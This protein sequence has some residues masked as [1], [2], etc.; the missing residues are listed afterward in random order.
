MTTLPNYLIQFTKYK[1]E[2]L[3]RN[4]K[5]I[6]KYKKLQRALDK[7][8]G[9]YREY[10]PPEG[11]THEEID[12]AK[13]FKISV[14][15]HPSASY[16]D[17]TKGKEKFDSSPQNKKS[18]K[19]KSLDLTVEEGNSVITRRF[20]LD[21][22]RL[23]YYWLHLPEILPSRPVTP[24]D[25]WSFERDGDDI[26]PYVSHRLAEE[27]TL[28]IQLDLKY[29][30][31]K[32]MT[33]LKFLLDEWK[34]RYELAYE[35]LLYRRF[36]EEREIRSHPTAEKL[37]GE[38][39]KMYEQELKKRKQKYEQKLHFDNFDEYLQVY[40]LRKKAKSWAEITSTLDLNS[41]Q[42]ARN[43]YRS[44]CE[45]IEKGVEAYVQLV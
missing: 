34:E 30:K 4:S 2:F 26:R 27:G 25:G 10:G 13:K 24:L 21:L 43:H 44:A 36:C 23:M 35:K 5:Y 40:D 20:G 3:R 19:D 17:W 9:K 37:M 18:C 12:F 8:Y 22:D 38:F 28:Q 45:L 33:E 15:L 31:H 16:D 6:V 29:S 11:L 1:W 42:T 32:L 41:I 7:R 39:E 14:P